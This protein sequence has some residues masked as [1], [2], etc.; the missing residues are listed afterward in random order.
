MEGSPAVALRAG[1]AL[2]GSDRWIEEQREERMSRF[3][4]YLIYDYKA[5]RLGIAF[6]VIAAATTGMLLEGAAQLSLHVSMVCCFLVALAV[7]L[8]MGLVYRPIRH[9]RAWCGLSK[10]VRPSSLE[11][12]TSIAGTLCT[13]SK[14]NKPEDEGREK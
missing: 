11:S 6:S 2:N 12:G 5:R 7:Q 9:V 1:A 4:S 10:M 13:S 14:I 8:G 3:D